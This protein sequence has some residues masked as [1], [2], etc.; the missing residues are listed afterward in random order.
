MY[1]CTFYSFDSGGGPRLEVE[2]YQPAM[3]VLLLLL[4]ACQLSHQDDTA[5]RNTTQEGDTGLSKIYKKTE[6][7]LKDDNTD[8]VI[9]H[10][11]FGKECN[12]FSSSSCQDGWQQIGEHCYQT[13]A[14]PGKTWQ[15]SE[16]HCEQEGGHLASVTTESVNNYF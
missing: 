15:E 7:D 9:Q 1:E 12:S 4:L 16:E 2:S 11:V 6:S 3:R 14:N 10:N 5:D 8:E 13:S